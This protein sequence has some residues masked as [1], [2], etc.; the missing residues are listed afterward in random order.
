[1]RRCVN[2]NTA[3]DAKNY[4][5]PRPRCAQCRNEV[6]PRAAALNQGTCYQRQASSPTGRS[7]AG[8]E[9]GFGDQRR[10][11]ELKTA[12]RWHSSNRPPWHD[13]RQSDRRDLRR[14]RT[15]SRSRSCDR[16]RRDKMGR[17]SN[18]RG[19]DYHENRG[20]RTSW[21][22][23]GGSSGSGGAQQPRQRGA[24]PPVPSSTSLSMA[25]PA[26]PREQ[27]VAAPAHASVSKAASPVPGKGLPKPAPTASAET[28]AAAAQGSGREGAQGGSSGWGQD[29][30]IHT[31]QQ[32]AIPGGSTP[33]SAVLATKQ[34]AKSVADAG[35]SGSKPSTIGLPSGQ[36]AQQT[37]APVSASAKQS[38]K[39]IGQQSATASG[40]GSDM[41]EADAEAVTDEREQKRLKKKPEENEADSG[42]ARRSDAPLDVDAALIDRA[43][44]RQALEK[45]YGDNWSDPKVKK[46][47]TGLAP[48]I[49][50]IFKEKYPILQGHSMSMFGSVATA[51][52]NRDSAAEAAKAAAEDATRKADLAAQARGCFGVQPAEV[53]AAVAAAAAAAAA[54]A[55]AAEANKAAAAEYALGKEKRMA[56]R[57]R[58]QE[59]LKELL[60]DEESKIDEELKIADDV[61]KDTP[62]IQL[63]KIPRMGSST[64][65]KIAAAFLSPGQKN[66]QLTCGAFGAMSSEAVS[67]KKVRSVKANRVSA[68]HAAIADR[69]PPALPYVAA[70]PNQTPQMDA[71]AHDSEPEPEP[72][73]GPHSLRTHLRL[74]Q[75]T[76]PACTSSLRDLS[77]RN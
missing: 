67:Q 48:G 73:A 37:A 10:D 8:P 49:E 22:A 75:P 31:E 38:S 12:D 16:D 55:S 72:P 41:D 9:G 60:Q 1:M 18:D 77:E 2:C 23:A 43:M 58:V 65:E 76:P 29:L 62:L 64:L 42:V 3:F 30:T 44:V 51:K 26:A 4:A 17:R 36:Q 5:G 19:R 56:C 59:L 33:G 11:R 66:W 52:A 7:Q 27:Q 63:K 54:A 53:Q 39:A 21:R 61:T 68:L 70:G 13:D 69:F 46:S 24:T 14:T 15:G 40:K 71:S 34:N 47:M 32:L 25:P 28:S 57:A 50:P 35:P 74:Q 20:D 6:T 45:V